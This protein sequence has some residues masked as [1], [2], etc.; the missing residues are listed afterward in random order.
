V[1]GERERTLLIRANEKSSSQM[2]VGRGSHAGR[3]R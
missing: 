3:M 2:V 1:S